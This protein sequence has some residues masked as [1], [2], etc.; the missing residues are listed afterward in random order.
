MPL[1]NVKAGSLSRSYISVK[2]EGNDK[3]IWVPLY[4]PTN[5][6]LF[7]ITY[8]YRG[9]PAQGARAEYALDFRVSCEVTFKFDHIA[10][11][12]E[13]LK[14]LAPKEPNIKT[15][16]GKEV[17]IPI[18]EGELLGFTNGGLGGGAWDFLLFNYA[19]E[20]SHINTSRWTSD[21]NK[22]ADCPY[23]YFTEDLKRQ[24]YAM[25]ASAGGEKSKN[26]T[27]RSASRD[28]AGTLS[29]GWFKGNSTDTRGSRILLGSDF[30]TVDIVRDEG[31]TLAQGINF[32][33]REQNAPKKPEEVTVGGSVC[34]TDGTNHAFLKLLS[35]TEMAA[36]IASG[37]CPSTFPEQYEIWER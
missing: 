12:S 28:V 37:H 29:G 11:I 35:D 14:E 2:R 36:S 20:V 17:S 31:D 32:S 19:K 34:Y 8:A 13:K 1:G 15:N 18:V 23:D 3:K 30:S 16:Q 33:L 24:Y 6:T 25:F 7:R 26:A 10:N 5:A 22:Y 27:C 21:H 4:A 9:D